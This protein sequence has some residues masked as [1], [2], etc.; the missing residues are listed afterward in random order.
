MIQFIGELLP[1]QATFRQLS[2][3]LTQIVIRA[4]AIHVMNA[5]VKI[6]IFSSAEGVCAAADLGVLLKNKHA[7]PGVASQES[8][9]GQRAQT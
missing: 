1:L 7:L 5:H 2:Q 8:R 4:D 9:G 6:G 3:Q